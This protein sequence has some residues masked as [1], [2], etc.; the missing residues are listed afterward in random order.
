MRTFP[1][2]Y[3]EEDTPYPQGMPHETA[4]HISMAV[5]LKRIADNLEKL[6]SNIELYVAMKD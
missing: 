4:A 1:N 5:S 6:N 3:L 2:D